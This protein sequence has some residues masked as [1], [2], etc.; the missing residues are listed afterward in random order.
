MVKVYKVTVRNRAAGIA[1]GVGIVGIG[2]LLLTVGLALLAAL[3]VA[4]GVLGAGYVLYHRLRGSRPTLPP[5]SARS[6]GLDPM[7]EVKPARPATIRVIERGDVA[8]PSDD[9]RVQ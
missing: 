2:I 3:A 5:Q 4:G 1:L 9:D 8:G 7:L 6:T